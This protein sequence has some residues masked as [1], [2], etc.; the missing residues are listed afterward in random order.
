M[1]KT[2]LEPQLRFDRVFCRRIV[3]W[4]GR[5]DLNPHAFRRHP[6]KM[7]CLPVPPLPLLKQYFADRLR[8]TKVCTAHAETITSTLQPASCVLCLYTR[9]NEAVQVRRWLVARS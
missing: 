7:V 2:P 9:S 5:G 6:L 3:R 1:H 8:E 4:C